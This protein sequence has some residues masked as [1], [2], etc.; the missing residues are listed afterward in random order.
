MLFEKLKKDFDLKFENKIALK[1]SMNNEY[2]INIEGVIEK[3]EIL[4]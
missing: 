3:G 4:E 1:S 2:I